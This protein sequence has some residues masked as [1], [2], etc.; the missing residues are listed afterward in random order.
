MW[1]VKSTSA[2]NGSVRSNNIPLIRIVVPAFVFMSHGNVKIINIVAT[3]FYLDLQDLRFS[4]IGYVQGKHKKQ[5]QKL[6]GFHCSRP[7]PERLDQCFFSII[8][9]RNSIDQLKVPAASC[10]PAE[11]G[12]EM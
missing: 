7:R 12:F 1:V 11:A 4:S 2:K 3:T 8:E 5:H 6:K 10:S 9:A